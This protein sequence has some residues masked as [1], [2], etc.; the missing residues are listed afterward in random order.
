[1][2]NIQLKAKIPVKM[3]KKMGGGVQWAVCRK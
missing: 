3:N 2:Y 1:M